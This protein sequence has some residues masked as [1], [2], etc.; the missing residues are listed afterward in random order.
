VTG[1]LAA[2]HGI[3]VQ[4]QPTRPHG[5]TAVVRLHAGLLVVE[6]PPAPH[7]LLEPRPQARQRALAPPA[8]A[9]EAGPVR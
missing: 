9:V 7:I 4:L 3:T 6:E 8:A 1:I 5:V 2:R